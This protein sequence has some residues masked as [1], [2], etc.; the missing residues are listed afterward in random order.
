MSFVKKAFK[1]V[2]NFVK[3]YWK[4]IVVAALVV[5]TAGIATVGFAA[6]AGASGFSGFMGAM[7]STMVAG[8]QGLGAA[9]GLGSGATTAGGLKV[10][11][12]A[13]A[14]A[15]GGA[16]W[17]VGSAASKIGAANAAKAAATNVVGTG[18]G[19]GGLVAGSTGKTAATNVVGNAATGATTTAAAGGGTSVG[20]ILQG[21][22]AV[23]G[24][25]LSAYAN[26][27]E[28]EAQNAPPLAQW[29]VEVGREDEYYAGDEWK[30]G[31]GANEQAGAQQ[32]AQQG[33]MPPPPAPTGTAAL[34]QQAGQD[35]GIQQA[36]QPLMPQ[37][38][39]A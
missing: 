24:P 1:K 14:G 3:K 31:D 9:V 21:V 4:V 6:F 15:N 11:L 30:Y 10:G 34:D 13:A 26:M 20:S 23:A 36:A 7:G 39:Y 25:A 32:M 16:G 27:K 18:K 37:G 2:K 22:G 12:G 33:L 19:V 35:V 38:G 8:V 5:F 17:A 28:A 29:G